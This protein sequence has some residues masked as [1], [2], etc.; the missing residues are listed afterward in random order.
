MS[1]F[2]GQHPKDLDRAIGRWLDGEMTS[3]E[4][5]EFERER[6]ARRELREEGAEL[7]AIDRLAAGALESRFATGAPVGEPPPDRSARPRSR[8]GLAVP[9]TSAAAALVIGLVAVAHLDWDPIGDAPPR[10]GDEG[11]GDGRAAVDAPVVTRMG[12][13]IGARSE[14]ARPGPGT[15]GRREV[16]HDGCAGR[17][18]ALAGKAIVEAGKALEQQHRRRQ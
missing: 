7:E 16:A 10:S 17:G 1:T 14:A 15:V 2:E 8:R 9:M 12:D 6:A 3:P 11:V 5:A 13:R 18:N 4:R